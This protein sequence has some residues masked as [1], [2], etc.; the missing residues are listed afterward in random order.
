MGRK[1]NRVILNAT[2]GEMAAEGKCVYKEDKKVV[3]VPHA[4]PG[5]VADL[6]VVRKKKSFEEAVIQTLHSPSPLRLTPFCDAFGLCGGCKWQHVSY[7]QQIEAKA[8][9]IKD[10]FTRIGKVKLPTIS[11]I[12]GSEKTTYYLSLI[13]I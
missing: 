11:P 1:R 4:A 8:Q 5:D 3:F 7:A 2:I 9:Q 10:A 13:H 6:R 12:L